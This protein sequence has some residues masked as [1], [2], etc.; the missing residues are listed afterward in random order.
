[1]NDQQ[2]SGLF[3]CWLRELFQLVNP[4]PYAQGTEQRTCNRRL[5]VNDVDIG[6]T[7]E[8]DRV[9]PHKPVTLSLIAVLDDQIQECKPM[10]TRAGTREALRYCSNSSE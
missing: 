9:A 8:V 7:E 1:M 4:L 5:Q 10:Q 3:Q 6:V 2:P